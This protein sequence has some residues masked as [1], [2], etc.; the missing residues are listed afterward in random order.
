MLGMQGHAEIHCRD[1][2]T[3]LIWL[4]CRIAGLTTDLHLKGTQFNTALAGMLIPQVAYDVFL[5]CLVYHQ[6]SMPRKFAVRRSLPAAYY[7]ANG[8]LGIFWLNCV[9]TMM[10]HLSWHP[11]LILGISL[12]LGL[13][14][15]EAEQMATH[16]RRCVGN[17]HN[18]HWARPELCGTHCHSLLSWIL[19]GR[20]PAWHRKYAMTVTLKARTQPRSGS[21][22]EHVIQTSRASDT[23][24]CPSTPIV[25]VCDHASYQRR[26]LLR[27]CVLI[28]RLWRCVLRHTYPMGFL[29]HAS[30]VCWRPRSR[31]W[32]A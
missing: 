11:M 6:Y 9:R 30:K 21:I 25:L 32:M 19:R 7:L 10:G 5:T 14:A 23:V 8:G 22:S 24:S 13:E 4:L 26:Y 20:T 3:A 17:G 15:G 2:H 1:P 18:A 16:H 12:E 27:I 29:Q 28:R 31:R